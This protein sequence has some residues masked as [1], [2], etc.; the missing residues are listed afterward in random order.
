[1]II[2]CE[3]GVLVR[4]LRVDERD[5]VI[6]RARKAGLEVHFDR[7]VKYQ[8]GVDEGEIIDVGP[9][10]WK[11]FGDTPWAKV[12]DRIVFAKHAGK[13]VFEPSEMELPEDKRTPYVIINGEDVVAV[14][15][16]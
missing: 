1:M 13:P 9:T 16:G 4:Q 7:N 8:A 5:Q 15:R 14:L 12:G 6:S 10:A 11:D 2:P 3:H